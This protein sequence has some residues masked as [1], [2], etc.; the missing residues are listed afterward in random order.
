MIGAT[1]TLPTVTEI[2]AAAPT[3]TF[4]TSSVGPT[5]GAVYNPVQTTTAIAPPMPAQY[6]TPVAGG[7]TQA[8][9]TTTFCGSTVTAPAPATTTFAGTQVVQ[10]PTVMTSAPATTVVAPA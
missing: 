10:A 8:P 1:Q 7:T 2:T 9:A 4:F 5:A 3:Q 6:L